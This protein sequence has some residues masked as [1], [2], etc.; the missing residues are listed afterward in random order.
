MDKRDQSKKDEIILR[1]LEVIRSMTEHNLSRMGTD[2]WGAPPVKKEPASPAP[3]GRK[4]PRRRRR[5]SRRTA[6]RPGSAWRICRRNWTV[7]WASP[8]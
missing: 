1:Q 6:P 8:P 3:E 4:K 7:M 5:G 2:F